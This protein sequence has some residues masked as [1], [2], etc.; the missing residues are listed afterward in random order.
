MLLVDTIAYTSLKLCFVIK[1][2]QTAKSMLVFQQI[3]IYVY[4]YICMVVYMARWERKRYMGTG[5]FLFYQSSVP[6]MGTAIIFLYVIYNIYICVDDCILSM[7]IRACMFQFHFLFPHSP[8]SSF[9]L[10][11]LHSSIGNTMEPCTRSSS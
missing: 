10:A 2:N 5:I 11:S 9:F 3:C 8:S 1:S 7:T 6:P 4:T